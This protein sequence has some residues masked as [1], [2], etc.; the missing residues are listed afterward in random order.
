M[1]KKTVFAVWSA[2]LVLLCGTE[3]RGAEPLMTDYVYPPIFQSASVLPNIMVVLDHSGSMCFPAYPDPFNPETNDPQGDV[4]G[5]VY[6]GLNCSA[7][8]KIAV[9]NDD[10]AERS[11]RVSSSKPIGQMALTTNPLYMS[12]DGSGEWIVGLR[13]ANVQV[14]KEISG[15]P[16][17]ITKAYITFTAQSASPVGNVASFTIAGQDAANPGTFTSTSK[18]ITNRPWLGTT[19]A[20]SAATPA[21]DALTAWIKDNKYNTPDLTPIVSDMVANAGWAKGNAMVFK[22]TGAAG[23][24]RWAYSRNGSATMSPKL[25]IEYEP[26]VPKQ[27]YGY[28]VP[29]ARYVYNSAAEYFE[30]TTLT[31]STTWSG[32]FLNWVCMR[33]FDV[34]KKVLVGGK[35]NVTGVAGGPAAD[36]D[37][38][39]GEGP[40]SLSGG[41]TNTYYWQNYFLD[42][43]DPADPKVSPYPEA[44]YGVKGGFLLVKTTG[45][46]PWNSPEA[47]FNI[48]VKKSRATEPDEYCMDDNGIWNVCGVMQKIG[49]QAQWANLWYYDTLPVNK[50]GTPI[51]TIVRNIEAKQSSNA[52]PTA[53][54]IR[55]VTTY[56][57]GA[58]S[59][60]DPFKDINGNIIP[61]AKSYLFLLTD[62]EPNTE[63][64]FPD[65][66]N[67]GNDS[68]ASPRQYDA[69]DDLAFYAHTNDLR[70]A[71]AGNQNMDTYVVYAFGKSPTAPVIL[72]E[73]AINGGFEDRN[74][75]GKPDGYPM[76]KTG[77]HNAAALLSAFTQYPADQRGEWDKDGDAAGTPDN[78]YEAQNGDEIESQV[79]AAINDILNQAASGTAVS[80]LATTG[81]GE[82]TLVQA[83]F[84]PG[85]V[86]GLLEVN[87]LGRLQSLWVDSKGNIREDTINDQKL[88]L[89]Q[90]NVIGYYFE[91]G[92]TRV[93]RFPVSEGN[94]YPDTTSATGGDNITL[95]EIQPI[96]EG[97]A[98]LADRAADERKIYTYVGN[99]SV[100]ASPDAFAPETAGNCIAFTKANAAILRPFL[101]IEDTDYYSYLH[102]T[103]PA[104]RAENLIEFI[105]GKDQAELPHTA[106]VRNRILDGKVWK[107]GDIVYSTPV[108]ISKPVE[109]YDIIYDDKTY[110]AF[111]RKYGDNAT[112]ARETVVYV[113]ANDGM[114]H[115]FSSGRFD[116]A[117][118][119]FN[120]VTSDVA[121]GDELWAYIPQALLPHL[122]WLADKKYG[123]ETH[124][125]FVDLKPKVVD[126][127]IFPD[128]AVHPGGWGTVLIGGMNFGGKDIWTNNIDGTRTDY[129]PS[130]FAIDITDP[131]NPRLLWDKWFP[132]M[133]FSMFQPTVI[134]VGRTFNAI[135]KTWNND[136]H[137]YL[138]IGSG[139]EQFNGWVPLHKGSLYIVDI[140]TGELKKQFQTTDDFANMNTPIAIDKGLNYSV[141]A[142]YVASNYWSWA[143]GIVEGKVYRLG[144][145]II[146]ATY[147]EG[148]DARYQWDPASMTN[149]W[150]W[151]TLVQ[152]ST[153]TGK[154]ILPLMSAPFTI[155]SDTK[156]NVWLYMGTGRFQVPTD[157]T[158][159][160]QNYLLGIRD[161][162]YD[163]KGLTK[164]QA[165]A[166]PPPC[167]HNYTPGAT[168]TLTPAKLFNA[169]F[170]DIKPNYVVEP[171]T[172]GISTLT[173]WQALLNEV[174]KTTGTPAYSFY[175]GWYRKLLTFG[176]SPSER[177]VNKPTVFGGIALFPTYVPDTNACSYGGF[178]NL[179]ALYYLTGTAYRREV[180]LGDNLLY[181]DRVTTIDN[182]VTIADGMYLGYGLSSS[183]GLHAYAEDKN[184][185]TLYSQMS[186]GVIN[187]I[188]IR[189]ASDTRSGI[190][191]WKEASGCEH[192]ACQ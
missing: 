124:V 128:D 156:D 100:M 184:E 9:N 172:G 36:N 85:K 118:G 120:Q 177:V 14:P 103:D 58:T 63:G 80:V 138:A 166:S 170:Y 161:P 50:M 133:G 82:G 115:A 53:N 105:R 148:K 134:S 42:P 182:E 51:P 21:P 117:T 101:G 90:D 86:M 137:W 89:A 99:R 6:E 84:L 171:Q 76:D 181:I 112:T 152:S 35:R 11:T 155:S 173:T 158:E 69:M 150:S 52:T 190:E 20:W 37:T 168:C 65:Y 169:S 142:L 41:S 62:G 29:T 16:V 96:W 130:F 5:A 136:D 176:I 22:I 68:G 15:V 104:Y 54:A 71:I 110:G 131:R 88:N 27:Y 48:A 109:K 31:D 66:D 178:S 154:V 127:R 179:Y 24:R 147:V 153:G 95:E 7:V 40:F 189:P 180:L 125:P 44:W 26:C 10:A 141:D 123:I 192:S 144:I 70:P 102:A 13:F 60:G 129:H 145:P 32:N 160:Q 57:K 45:Q 38:L 83:I 87:W 98:L 2:A 1:R 165:A 174:N 135:P 74:K 187:E 186:T 43:S 94:E 108:T 113:G 19:V 119:Q 72:R 18:D 122:K 75:N 55:D 12:Y 126:V 149:P 121:V 78:Y 4:T 114:L 107:L 164:K 28:F 188:R 81:E 92:Q 46:D 106:Q 8:T 61:C 157:K 73:T 17:T 116:K 47:T 56:F 93:K 132:Q 25:V 79:L 159:T 139:L 185:A 67:D 140:L 33:R 64:D 30:R 143:N 49:S 167:Y 97:G 163:R 39:L 59:K 23:S 111:Q 77:D 146:N 183:F 151:T 162:F 175:S 34:L 3:V 191:S 91:D